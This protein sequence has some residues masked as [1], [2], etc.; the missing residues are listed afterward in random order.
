[1]NGLGKTPIAYHVLPGASSATVPDNVV[2]PGRINTE[3]FIIGGEYELTHNIGIGARLPFTFGNFTPPGQNSRAATALGSLE[4]EGAYTLHLNEQM[5][6]VYALGMSLPTAQGDEVPAQE[7]LDK[8]RGPIDQGNYDRFSV[9]HAASA[10]RAFEESALFEPKRLGFIPKVM[11]DYNANKIMIQPY[12]KMENLIST[13][14]GAEHSYI[15]E[16]ILGAFLGYRVHQYFDTGVRVWTNVAFA[17]GGDTV[18]AVE[19]QIRGH[20]GNVMPILGG[21]IPFAGLT[22]PQFGGIRLALAARF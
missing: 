11:F 10:S 12:I 22:D 16:L 2:G 3:S 15:G 19:P 8:I 14:S 20:I 17:G 1:L 6:L 7:E 4:V 18:A 9:N 13:V 21:V 5:K